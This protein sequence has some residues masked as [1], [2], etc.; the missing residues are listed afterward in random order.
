[1]GAVPCIDTVLLKFLVT[2]FFIRVLYMYKVE[3]PGDFITQTLKSGKHRI[4]ICLWKTIPYL[5]QELVQWSE[6]ALL[7]ISNLYVGEMQQNLAQIRVKGLFGIEQFQL[8]III[9]VSL[10]WQQILFCIYAVFLHCIAFFKFIDCWSQ[11]ICDKRTNSH[12]QNSL[13]LLWQGTVHRLQFLFCFRF[14]RY[15]FLLYGV[16]GHTSNF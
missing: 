6:N 12:R 15:I 3:R 7:G 14:F 9:L 8:P 16:N 5:K 13:F 2:F 11:W 4:Y 10:I 1:M